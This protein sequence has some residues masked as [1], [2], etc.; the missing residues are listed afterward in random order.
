MVAIFTAFHSFTVSQCCRFTYNHTTIWPDDNFVKSLSPTSLINKF[1]ISW[2]VAPASLLGFNI[3]VVI[4]KPPREN[5]LSHILKVW[6]K[7]VHHN[8][9]TTDVTLIQAPNLAMPQ[10]IE[11][12]IIN[13]VL[14]IMV[15]LSSLTKS[16]PRCTM[17]GITMLTICTLLDSPHPNIRCSKPF[18]AGPTHVK[19]SPVNDFMQN[20][21]SLKWILGHGLLPNHHECNLFTLTRCVF[22]EPQTHTMD[23]KHHKWMKKVEN[24]GTWHALCN[25][26]YSTLNSHLQCKPLWIPLRS[27]SEGDFTSASS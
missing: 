25:I 6:S 8:D 14:Y 5:H 12:I 20:I 7:Q 11:D 18:P 13:W 1:L 9:L 4:E 2:W 26:N 19:P 17:L 15:N 24:L 23:G 27:P 22:L 16:L 10:L 21:N 3:L